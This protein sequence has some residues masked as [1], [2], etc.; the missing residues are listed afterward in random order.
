MCL[1]LLD[2]TQRT[3]RKSYLTIL[4]ISW[5]LV[6]P[7]LNFANELATQTPCP[8]SA[9]TPWTPLSC[10]QFHQVMCYSYRLLMIVLLYENA[11]ELIWGYHYVNHFSF[12]CI[13]DCFS[14]FWAH[15]QHKRCH[16]PWECQVAIDCHASC[17]FRLTGAM[18]T[19][20]V[21]EQQDRPACGN[22]LIRLPYCMIVAWLMFDPNSCAPL[23]QGLMPLCL[24]VFQWLISSCTASLVMY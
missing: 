11:P 12:T 23:H 7:A 1:K 2:S 22:R 10:Y 5:G 16:Q 4:L 8:R 9:I 17:K 21:L 3:L 18:R 24:D 6:R 13:F 14:R 20:F 15:V 19:V